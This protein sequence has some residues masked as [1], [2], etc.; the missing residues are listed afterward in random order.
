MDEDPTELVC[1]LF[2]LLTAQLEDSAALAMEGQG[3]HLPSA[4]HERAQLLEV[5]IRDMHIIARAMLRLT[6]P[7][8][9]AA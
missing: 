8:P 7:P 2:A 3:K 9:V 4:Q 1:Q 6:Q 5:K